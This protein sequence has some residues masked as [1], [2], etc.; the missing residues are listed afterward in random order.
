M[1]LG[2][3][4]HRMCSVFQEVVLTCIEHPIADLIDDK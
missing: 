4:G 1:M 3:G 2:T